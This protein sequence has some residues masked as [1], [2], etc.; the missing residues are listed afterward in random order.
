[1]LI[2]L[3]TPNIPPINCFCYW[4]NNKIDNIIMT[5]KFARICILKNFSKPLPQ[6]FCICFDSQKVFQIVAHENI[7]N[8]Y[9][10]YSNPENQLSFTL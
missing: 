2:E 10:N 3:I 1:M 4:E 7:L 5:G 9:F 6:G 8:L